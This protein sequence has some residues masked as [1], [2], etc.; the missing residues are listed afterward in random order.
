MTNKVYYYIIQMIDEINQI[1]NINSINDF[2]NFKFSI[3]T[4]AIIAFLGGCAFLVFVIILF[5]GVNNTVDYITSIIE[6]TKNGISKNKNISIVNFK[7]NRSSYKQNEQ[8][9]NNE[10]NEDDEDD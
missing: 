4:L 8:N 2:L 1:G 6:S 7:Q 5:G 3:K 9:Q 10:N